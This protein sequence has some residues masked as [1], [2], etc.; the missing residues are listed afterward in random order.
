MENFERVLL[1]L[2]EEDIVTGQATKK[3][4]DFL[5]L[6]IVPEVLENVHANTSGYPRNYLLQQLATRVSTDKLIVKKLKN[7][8]RATP[9]HAS[10]KLIYRKI[11]EVNLKKQNMPLKTRQMLKEKFQ[12]NVALLAQ[13]TRIP[14]QEFWTDFK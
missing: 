3:I 1:L 10:S 14:V 6:E 7:I 4:L 12:D 5:N 11:L 2:F 13:Q 8:I 9:L